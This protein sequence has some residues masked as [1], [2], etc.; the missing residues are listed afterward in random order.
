MRTCL[1][2]EVV[3]HPEELGCAG[4]GRHHCV[5]VEGEAWT[6]VVEPG[7]LK[8]GDQ[9]FT[10]LEVREVAHTTPGSPGRV[11]VHFV[12]GEGTSYRETARIRLVRR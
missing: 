12:G 2:H 6:D 1:T 7:F 4:P 11:N 5:V 10:G 3:I 8:G 9:V